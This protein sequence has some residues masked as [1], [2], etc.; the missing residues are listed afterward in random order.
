MCVYLVIRQCN[1]CYMGS[2]RRKLKTRV[3]EHKSRIRN[4]VPDVPMVQHF[5]EFK[6]RADDFRFMVLEIVTQ[7]LDKGG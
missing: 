3:I 1:L 2:T 7:P 5:L 4:R 6:Y